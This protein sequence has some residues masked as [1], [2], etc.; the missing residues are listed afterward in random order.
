MSSE[1]SELWEEEP[2]N[3]TAP[4]PAAPRVQCPYCLSVIDGRADVCRYC[5]RDVRRILDLHQQL[6]QR[7]APRPPRSPDNQSRYSPGIV[8]SYYAIATLIYAYGIEHPEQTWLPNAVLILAFVTGIVA[9]PLSLPANLWHL[10]A[11]G[12]AQPAVAIIALVML[13]SVSVDIAVVVAQSVILTGART[14]LALALG[15][16]VGVAVMRAIGVRAAA[17][18][19][20]LASL[21]AWLLGSG[22]E[23]DRLEKAIVKGAAIAGPLMQFASWMR[24]G[25]H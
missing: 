7:H 6:R 1:V 21:R 4:N 20:S 18:T 19:F 15:G 9:G 5:Q 12:L 22:T 16:A 11:V 24:G 25:E 3:D 10:F 14:G 8:F 13:G 23:L 2:A 17:I